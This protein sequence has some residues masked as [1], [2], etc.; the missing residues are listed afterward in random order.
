MGYVFPDVE[1]ALLEVLDDL[2]AGY[3]HL[4]YGFEADLPAF[5]VY[6]VGGSEAGPLREDRV[7]VAVYAD[8]RDAARDASEAARQRLVGRPH[9]TSV[10]LLDMLD[11]EISPHGVPYASDVVNQYVTTYRVAT[12]PVTS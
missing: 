11:V 5:H 7:E 12:R 8:G 6:T 4:S 1:V 2:G 3:L 10:G 9:L